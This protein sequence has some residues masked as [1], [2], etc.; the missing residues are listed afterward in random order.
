MSS[1]TDY[2]IAFG[3]LGVFIAIFAESG[4][5]LGF[6]LPGD[7]LLFSIGLLASKGYFNIWILLVLI[8]IAAI[9]GDS[10]GYYVGR[11]A[12][13]KVF[14]R[15]D[16]VFFSK[17]YVLKTEDFFNRHGAKSII[18]ARFIPVVRTFAPI[19]AGVG[20][21]NYRTFLTY[22]ITG[23]VLWGGSVLLTGYYLAEKIPGIERYTE[24]IIIGIIILSI[25]PVVF[26]LLKRK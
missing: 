3:Y 21:M 16:S 17:N 13:P 19:C 25:L 7:S 18:L 10:F 22:N 26:H 15:G 23:G 4:F 12:G 8:I 2:I 20:K 5:L 14:S 6:F 24:A 11:K 9:L 1:I